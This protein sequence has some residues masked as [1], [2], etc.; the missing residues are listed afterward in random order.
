MIDHS[1]AVKTC[2]AQGTYRVTYS[3]SCTLLAP[4]ALGVL[5]VSLALGTC[6]SDLRG[7]LR[8]GD[9]S[10]PQILVEKICPVTASTVL[11]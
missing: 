1:L 9:V 5:V 7:A 2:V 8:V 6:L 10:R 3:C 4:L 11:V